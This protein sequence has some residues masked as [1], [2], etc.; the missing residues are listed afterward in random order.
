[1]K[2]FFL[3]LVFLY[4]YSCKSQSD[5]WEY[6]DVSK[7]GLNGIKDRNGNEVLPCQ[8]TNKYLSFVLK[9]LN[10]GYVIVCKGGELNDGLYSKVKNGRWGMVDIHNNIII[11][12]EYDA[13]LAPSEGLVAVCKGGEKIFDPYHMEKKYSGGKW[14]YYDIKNGKIAIPLSYDS[15]DSFKE[16]I[17][18]VSKGGVTTLIRN[19]LLGEED[20]SNILQQ[21]SD[22]DLDI[23]ITPKQNENHFAFIFTVENYTNNIVCTGTN[24]DGKIVKE[25]FQKTLGIPI[26][27]ISYYPNG[28]FSNFHSMKKRMIDIANVFE[29]DVHFIVYFSGFGYYNP[30]NGESFLLPSDMSLENII[31]TSYRVTDIYNSLPNIKSCIIIIDASFDGKTREGESFTKGRGV[32]IKRK[33]DLPHKNAIIMSADS[34]GGR[35]YLD[36]SGTHG[37]FTYYLLKKIKKE[38]GEVTISD[39][40]EDVSKNIAKY[41]IKSGKI[42]IQKPHVLYGG[43]FYKLKLK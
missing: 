31:A 35:A 39:L 30:E 33:H 38:S 8:Y 12:F 18:M 29:D 19:P 17:A 40:F 32:S 25:Y 22:V 3:L 21:I 15:A 34:E 37:L 43:N 1:M 13:I 16:G 11:P 4:S 24:N 41:C 20:L 9:S 23:P 5:Y 27:N 42:D 2:L 10:S 28:T 14:G 7:N 6:S 26:N 36:E